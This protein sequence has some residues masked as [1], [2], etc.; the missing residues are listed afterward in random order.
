MRDYI[1]LGSVPILEDCAQVGQSDYPEKSREECRK[2]KQL[3]LNKFG[4]PPEGAYLTV[5]TFNHD[6]GLYREVCV[7]FDS[8]NEAAVNYAFE[9]ENN[10]PETWDD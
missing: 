10:L 5:K 8:D 4:Q 3:L 1:G 6:F 9:M 2:Y 7:V